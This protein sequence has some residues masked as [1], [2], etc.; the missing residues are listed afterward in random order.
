MFHHSIPLILDSRFLHAFLSF[1]LYGISNCFTNSH[2]DCDL[3]D[4]TVYNKECLLMLVFLIIE[5]ILFS[6][7]QVTPAVDFQNWN[8]TLWIG[9]MVIPHFI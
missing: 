3:S 1:C 8:N 5:I 7:A 4:V 6:N 2:I 9:I